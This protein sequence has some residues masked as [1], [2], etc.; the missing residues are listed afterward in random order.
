MER[1][2]GMHSAATQATGG[3]AVLTERSVLLAGRNGVLE[4]PTLP[5]SRH[6]SE[7]SMIYRGSSH[8]CH[9]GTGIQRTL[10]AA[11]RNKKYILVADRNIGNFA[12]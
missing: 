5:R 1:L 8:R 6:L 10:Y 9:E 3:I 11:R 4:T 12:A 7:G 2:E